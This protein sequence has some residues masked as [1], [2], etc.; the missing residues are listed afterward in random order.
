MLLKLITLGRLR[1]KFYASRNFIK[2]DDLEWARGTVVELLAQGAVSR[3]S[4]L[5]GELAAA[6]IEVTERPHLIM[7]LIAADKSNST[8][9]DRKHRLIHDC[10]MLNENLV[11]W[12]FELEKLRDFAKCLTRGDRMVTT[13]IKSAYH[14]VEIALR[15]R[16]LLGF[17]LDGVDYVYCALLSVAAFTFC[18]FAGVAADM[19]RRS[20]LCKALLWHVDDFNASIGP[21]ADEARARAIVAKIESLGFFINWPKTDLSM[22][23]RATSLGLI[24]DTVDMS[25]GIPERRL[26]KL[27]TLASTVLRAWRVAGGPRPNLPAAQPVPHPLH[28]PRGTSPAVRH[29]RAPHRPEPS[30]DGAVGAA[31]SSTTSHAPPDAPA[32]TGPDPRV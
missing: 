15:H 3:W 17:N 8:P 9:E 19:L 7:P 5:A 24:L 13:D 20:G 14:H 29:D 30:G 28:A 1:T 27:E 32:A 25:Y 11:H 4:D 16:T 22:P 2:D 6:G 21:E 31:A 10:R 18:K 23:T 12:P 26:L